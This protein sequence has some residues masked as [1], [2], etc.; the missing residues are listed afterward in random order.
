MI[1]HI[2]A[3]ITIGLAAWASVFMLNLD[4]E[5]HKMDKIAAIIKSTAMEDKK[6]T[7]QKPKAQ[8]KTVV[9]TS[10]SASQSTE[11]KSKEME[12]KLKALKERAGNLAA[13]TVSP[14]YKKQCSSCHGNVGEGI[15]GPKL[16]GRDKEYILANLKAFKAGT[17]KNYVMYGI[18]SHLDDE[19]MNALAE[20]ISTFQKK[21]DEATKNQ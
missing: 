18:L 9:N 8:P 10:S 3:L 7:G 4:K 5:V 6:L 15:I 19:Q 17:R 1:K 21:F 14:L 20:E 11:S 12:E 13:F 16:M 2:I